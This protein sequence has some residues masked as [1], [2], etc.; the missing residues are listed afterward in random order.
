MIDPQL[1]QILG[2]TDP[3]L[4]SKLTETV[5]DLTYPVTS[6][7]E[8]EAQDRFQETIVQALRESEEQVKAD[9]AV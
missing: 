6:A 2:L 4:D 5:G 9:A 7:A 3:N 1:E 8:Q